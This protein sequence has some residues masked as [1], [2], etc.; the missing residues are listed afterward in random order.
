MSF[1]C[2]DNERFNQVLVVL[3]EAR[4]DA[5]VAACAGR[6]FENEV[7]RAFANRGNPRAV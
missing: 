7:A 3:A 1:K 2:A 4:Y 6:S 5:L